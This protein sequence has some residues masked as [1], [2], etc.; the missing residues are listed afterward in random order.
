MVLLFFYFLS[1]PPPLVAADGWS[2]LAHTGLHYRYFSSRKSWT[3]AQCSCRASAPA[4]YTGE[5]ASVG[6]SATNSF[7]ANLPGGVTRAWLGGYQRNGAANGA[8]WSWSDGSAWGYESW[9]SGEPNNDNGEEHYLEVNFETK[10][11]WN[12]MPIDGATYVEGYICQY[13][14]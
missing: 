11:S 1:F 8:A 5:L 13:K 14:G 10:R 9:A 3:D 6:D 4:D 2:F 12:D 7:V